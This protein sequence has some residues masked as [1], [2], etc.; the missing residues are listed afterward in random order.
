[1][2]GISKE[3][4]A[5]RAAEQTDTIDDNLVEMSLEDETIRVHAVCVDDHKRLGWKITE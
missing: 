1:M 4:R 2:A 3:E 5:R